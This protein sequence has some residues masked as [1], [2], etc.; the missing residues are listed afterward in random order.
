MTVY[1]V[2]QQAAIAA[3]DG[4][5]ARPFATINEAASI[6]RAGDEIVVH[7]G[8]Y[9]ESVDPRYGGESADNRIVY[10]AAEGEPR[11]VIKGSERVTTWERVDEQGSPVA[12]D[13]PI[14]AD[15]A[16]WKAVL[17]NAMFGSF[18]PY[19]RTVYGD[20]V[21]DASSHARA[22]R[23]GDDGLSAAA[24]AAAAGYLERPACHLGDVYLNG[25]SFYEAF[26]LAEVAHPAPRTVGFDYGAWRN[27]PILDDP[28]A[29]LNVWYA[30]VEG[31]ER[32]G[33]TT[34][35]ANF[36]DADP[37][38]QLVEI[39]VRET[40]F[41]PSKPQVNYI[42]VRG[43]ELAQ[44][45]TPW[46]PPTGD[47]VGLI[48]AHWSRGWI[49]EGNVIHD[50]KCSAVSLGKEGSTGDS[51]CTRTRR[52]SGYQ[53]QMEAVFKALRFGWKKGVVGGH[54]VRG[55]VI[56]DC[57]QN[58]VVGHMGCAFSTIE[59][60]EI[61]NIATKHEFWGH[62]IGGIKLHAAVDTVI[63]GNNVHDCTLG[64]WLD[65]QTQGTHIDRNV[66]WKNMRDI[67]IEVS[68][69]PYTVSD[70]VL[71]SPIS[72]DV[73]SDGGAYVNNLIA[74]TIR[75]GRVLDRSTPYHFPHTTEPAGSAFVYGGDD[76]FVN[77]LFVQPAGTPADADEQSGWMAEGHGTR[78]YNLQARHEKMLG[79]GE[80][81]ERPVTLD[82]YRALASRV[83]GAADEE[84]FRNVPQPVLARDNTYL[85]GARELLGE[86]GAIVR[87][88]DWTV[89]LAQDADDRHVTLTVAAVPVDAADAA[90]AADLSV[91]GEGAIVCTA[92]LG[93]PRVVEARFEHPDGMPFVFDTDINGTPRAESSS[94][95]PL[96]GLAPGKSATVW[97]R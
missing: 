60:N 6:A 83:V 12:A 37:N 73:I 21:I 76:R 69:G 49:I 95:G 27:G 89:A 13:A 22:L 71:A 11:P 3:A 82:D 25:K 75:L 90:D 50:A 17:P 96:A 93:E 7:A 54:V 51:D 94:R 30:K 34:I 19:S 46:A 40:C 35:W 97:A 15:G 79:A 91:F 23:E 14:P 72:L 36:H 57:G 4:S 33:T 77:N 2:S 39:N 62:E 58:G 67:M 43:F 20:W 5:E 81:G 55:N 38:E 53:Y 61:F 78:A 66:F 64:M 26:S 45:A 70:N 84:V 65:W 41:Y 87:G 85:G 8:V 92:D 56:H 28:A 47:Q 59:R 18:N 52:K 10:R 80:H 42:T 88:G 9:R 1:H 32:T 68:H 48:G 86:P 31:D 74:G 29:T 24:Q 44:A 63:R 16:V